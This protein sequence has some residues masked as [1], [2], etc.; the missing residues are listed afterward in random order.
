MSAARPSVLIVGPG[1]NSAGGVWSVIST[2]MA[3]DLANRY[4]LENIATHRDGSRWAKLGQ[5]AVGIGQVAMRLTV[6][7]PDLVWIHTSSNASARRKTVVMTLARL[8]RVPRVLHVHGSEFEVAYRAAKPAEQ[9]M[10]RLLLRSANL[11]IALTPTWEAR[12]QAMTPCVTTTVMNP[13]DIPPAADPG[14]RMPG[15]I[16]SLGRVGER[17]GSA[18]I[19]A[20]LAELADRHPEAHVILAGDG[21]HAPVL[22]AAQTLGIADRLEM[23]S[24]MTP[25]QVA[26]LLDS[27]AIFTLPSREEGLPV[28]MLEAMAH[29]LPSVVTPVGGI[30][31]FVHDGVNGIMVQPDDPTG[32]AQ[33]LE[34]L[35]G[36][37][38]AAARLGDAARAEVTE[39]CAT[40]NA[41][42]QIDAAFRSV[43]GRRAEH[44]PRT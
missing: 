38:A 3:S 7:R 10:V 31:D 12:L 18:V 15:R 39:R 14:G 20:A 33:A 17:K 42:D 22:A 2:M 19:V 32:L 44:P 24:W 28:A 4:A 26:E 1:A 21:D 6:K 41:V 16:V 13:V 34:T 37:P 27:A 43:L 36:D 5:A 30:P 25:T 23:R 35:L 11:I 29:G 9:A 8:L 40:P